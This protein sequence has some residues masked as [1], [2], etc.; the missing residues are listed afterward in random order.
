MC[1][2][3]IQKDKKLEIGIYFCKETESEGKM[4]A[5]DINNDG[6]FDES[7]TNLQVTIEEAWKRFDC[8][9]DGT[10]SST[11][12]RDLIEAI[13][14]NYLNDDEHHIDDIMAELDSSNDG[15]LSKKEFIAWWTGQQGGNDLRKLAEQAVK[16]S[17]TD[18][19]KACWEGQKEIVEHFLDLSEKR[20]LYMENQKDTTP[21]GDGYTPLHYAAY[22]GHLKICEL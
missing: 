13:D 5:F 18:I 10:I 4:S 7:E 3:D 9:G 11:E 16:K 22:Q 14:E 21:F 6:V 12:L 15:V 1:Y 20:G 8:N 2:K 17:K 19:F